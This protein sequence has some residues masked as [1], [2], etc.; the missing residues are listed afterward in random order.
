MQYYKG[1]FVCKVRAEAGVREEQWTEAGVVWS[2]GQ[3]QMA[4]VWSVGQRYIGGR[5]V[6]CGQCEEGLWPV[7]GEPDGVRQP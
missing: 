4:G 1:L 2:V 7:F 5:S 6:E 3:R